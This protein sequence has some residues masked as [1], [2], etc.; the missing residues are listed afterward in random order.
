[1]PD[2]EMLYDLAEFFKV[3]AD[4]TRIKIIYALSKS[5][6]CVCDI[7]EI[8]NVSQSAVSHQLRMLKQMKLVKYRREGKSIFYSLSDE[9]IEDIFNKGMEHICE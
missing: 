2:D 8:L 5:E 9:H 4:S 6:L 1:M 3:F 7:S